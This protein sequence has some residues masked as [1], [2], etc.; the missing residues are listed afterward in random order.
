M[1]RKHRCSLCGAEGEPGTLLPLL[2]NSTWASWCAE[3][4]GIGLMEPGPSYLLETEMMKYFSNL[5]SCSENHTG[6]FDTAR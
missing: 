1:Y 3:L 5:R 6:G 2:T 4:E